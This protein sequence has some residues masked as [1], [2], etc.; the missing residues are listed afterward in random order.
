MAPL[1]VRA[2]HHG[3]GRDADH[4]VRRRPGRCTY[5]KTDSGTGAGNF[6]NSTPL[7]HVARRAA[8]CFGRGDLDEVALYDRALDR[9]DDRRAL[10]EL[11]HEPPARRARSPPPRT[12]R[13][14]SQTVTFNGSTSSDPDGTIVEVRVG[15]RRQRHATRPTPARRRRVTRSYATAQTS[16]SGCASPTT[17]SAPT[18]ETTRADRRQPAADRL[19]HGA[20]RTRRIVDQAVDL[21]RVGLQRRRRHDRQVRVGPRRQRHLRDRHRHHADDDARPTRTTGTV[22]VGLRVTDNGGKTGTTIARRSRSTTAASAA[23]A[24]RCSTRPASST[25]GAWARRPARRSP[26]ARARATATAVSGPTFGVPG[27]DRR[28]TPNTAV[29]LQR[30]QRLRRARTSN[31][32][33]TS[34]DDGRVLAQVERA[35]PTTTRSRWSSRRTSTADAGGFLV[36]PER[37]AARRHVRRRPR[38]RRHAQQ[39][40]LRR[41]PRAGAWHHYA[42]VIDTD[43]AAPRRRSRPTSTARPSRTRSST[44]ARAPA[45]S[46]TRR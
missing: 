26:T 10:P 30:R 2:R 17:C 33:G 24:T 36:D 4:A 31:L 6:A 43:G 14:S 39:R 37:P 18:R 15:P 34:D 8:A 40:L 12:R 3:A 32:S 21:Q 16:T 22:N 46:P 41:G 23:T 29:A 9:G 25:T 42:F 11:R 7:L 45:T 44:A 28:T 1:R 19:V 27:G 35:T 13:A 38:A 5:T 20:R